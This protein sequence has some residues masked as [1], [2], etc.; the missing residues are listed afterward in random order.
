MIIFPKKLKNRFLFHIP[1]NG[2]E[3]GYCVVDKSILEV[4]TPFSNLKNLKMGSSLRTIQ[5]RYRS[6]FSLIRL[7]IIIESFI[8]YYTPQNIAN[9]CFKFAS[10]VILNTAFPR[11]GNFSKKTGVRRLLTFREFIRY[12]DFQESLYK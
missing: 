2:C 5:N 1:Q 12:S 8:Y 4:S 10:Y 3:R 7:H 6:K 11:L 9:I